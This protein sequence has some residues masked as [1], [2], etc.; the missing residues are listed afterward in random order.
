MIFILALAGPRTARITIPPSN[1][2]LFNKWGIQTRCGK[3]T[4]ARPEP[5]D[6]AEIDRGGCAGGASARGYWSRPRVPPR[7]A[8]S[9]PTCPRRLLP[10]SIC[11]TS[12][13]DS[14]LI[15]LSFDASGSDDISSQTQPRA[16]HKHILPPPPRASVQDQEGA[17][18][19]R[20]EI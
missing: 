5:S 1:L 20:P 9:R 7:E 4:D 13:R 11:S 10:T 2:L 15:S 19:P 12:P 16:P 14:T 17:P 6:V 18:P 3:L 8:I